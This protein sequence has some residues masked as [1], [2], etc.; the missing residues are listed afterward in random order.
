MKHR[1]SAS[2]EEKNG[3]GDELIDYDNE[4]LE[5]LDQHCF[6]MQ[7]G[8]SLEIPEHLLAR[9][10]ELSEMLDCMNRLDSFAVAPVTDQKET[11]LGDSP[12]FSSSMMQQLP[13]NFGSFCLEEEIG[14]GGMGIIYKARHITLQ[15]HFALKMI[16]TCEFAT[17][18]EVR[19]FYQEARAASRLRHPNIVSVHDAGEQD[20]YPFLVMTYIEGQTLAEHLKDQKLEI[21]QAIDY[22]IQV[23]NAV[24]Y[25]HRQDII[26]RDLKPSNILLDQQHNAFV[27]DFGLAKVFEA[28]SERTISGTIL[29]TPAY[30]APE[31]AWGKINKITTQCDIYS[32]GAI[33][34]ELLTSRPPFVEESPLDQILRL[35]DSEPP[36]PGKINP[37]VPK[38]LEQICLRCLEKKPEHRYKSAG[39][40]ANDLQ[41]FQE[42]EPIALNSVGWWTKL[43]RWA[44]REPALVVH[45]AAFLIV[46]LILQIVDWRT[47]GH[48][49]SYLPVISILVAWTV[50]SVV[51]QKLMTRGVPFIRRTWI[52][53][54]AALFTAAVANAEGPVESLVTGYA[55]LIVTSSMWYKPRLVAV[56]TIASVIS[57]LFLVAYRGDPETPGHFP[58]LVIG[59]LLVIGGIVISLVRRILKLVTIRSRL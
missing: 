43:R 25:L 35:R 38:P 34:Y 31:Q 20:G 32:L 26:H 10:P 23:A 6:A 37:S 50:I 41:H 29:G 58:Y 7:A 59:I 14:R 46:A 54:D 47:P 28:D 53:A 55:L 11:L 15:S 22:V 9:H 44:R 3:S 5:F 17:D 24:D 2:Q 57:Y 16:R 21:S 42:G 19:R 33:L 40:L 49:Q 39:E 27:T 18:E 12:A 4:V 36:A 51:F 8:K 56:T 45:L 1:M 48:R 52:A 30:M 13:R